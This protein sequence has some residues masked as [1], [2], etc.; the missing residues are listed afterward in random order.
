MCEQKQKINLH[1]RIPQY[2]CLV[3]FLFSALNCI[4]QHI[5]LKVLI[6]DVTLNFLH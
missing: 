6:Q 4:T 1:F 5:P 3:F 2:N